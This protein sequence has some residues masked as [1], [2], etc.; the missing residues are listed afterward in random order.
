MGGPWRERGFDAAVLRTPRP[1]SVARV[2]A[3]TR[4]REEERLGRLVLIYIMAVVTSFG[5]M[6]AVLQQGW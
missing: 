6:V 5:L 3:L 4:P 1:L 2:Q